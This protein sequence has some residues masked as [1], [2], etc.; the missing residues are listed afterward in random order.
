[1]SEITSISTVA[2]T[3]IAWYSSHV[4]VARSSPI[5]LSKKLRATKHAGTDSSTTKS[6]CTA[7]IWTVAS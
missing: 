5:T 4:A 1:M 3:S 7:T 2:G 6:A